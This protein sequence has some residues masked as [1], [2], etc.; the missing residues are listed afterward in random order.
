MKS[1]MD[2]KHDVENELKWEPSVNEAHVG[3]TAKDGVITLTGHVPSYM[4]NYGA[5]R[6]VKRVAG[7]KAVVNELDVTL[8]GSSK[9]TD[10]DIAAAC[11][12]ALK[13]NYAVPDD[14]IK[15][16]VSKGRVTLEGEV[17]WQYQKEAALKAVRGLTGVMFV[18]NNIAIKARVS[19]AD[20]KSKIE[21]AFKRSAQ[22]D[23]A[24]LRVEA[25]G[26]K[27][28]LSGRVRSW[29]EHDQAQQAAWSAPGVSVVENDVVVIQ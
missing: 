14:K 6:A 11:L 12:S 27:V 9:R 26:G 20:V 16:M 1:D 8:P 13:A 23:A 7:V 24:G 10:E 2:L 21:A 25:H 18:S 19:E 15:V 4:E 5:A 29:A 22:I 17:E 28:T 3:V